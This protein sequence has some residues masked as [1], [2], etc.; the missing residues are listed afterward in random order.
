MNGFLVVLC[1]GMDD[2]PCAFV[3]ERWEAEEKQRDIEA[4][5]GL[6]PDV[7]EVNWPLSS[8]HH[9]CVEDGL[10][11]LGGRDFSHLIAVRIVQFVN[12]VP[13]K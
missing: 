9:P 13:T 8:P 11:A 7:D 6:G 10:E 5:Y 12:G 4:W 2:I 3:Q 1:C